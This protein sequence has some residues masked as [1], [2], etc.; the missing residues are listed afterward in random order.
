MMRALRKKRDIADAR[1]HLK[2]RKLLCA[3]HLMNNAG[4]C[5]LTPA[6]N[7]CK[8]SVCY[9]L[10]DSPMLSIKELN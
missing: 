5:A 3:D 6:N 2:C 10:G 9:G 1:F 4:K 7:Q 8:W